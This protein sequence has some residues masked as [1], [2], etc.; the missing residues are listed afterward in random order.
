MGALVNYENERNDPF[1]YIDEPQSQSNVHQQYAQY[2]NYLRTQRPDLY[3]NM[4]IITCGYDEPMIMDTDPSLHNNIFQVLNK[5]REEISNRT[6]EYGQVP[7]IER[8]QLR[9]FYV[10]DEQRFIELYN[11]LSY[12]AFEFKIE[13]V[14]RAAYPNMRMTMRNIFINEYYRQ[15]DPKNNQYMTEQNNPLYDD[16]YRCFDMT[17]DTATNRGK[18][19]RYIASLNYSDDN[20]MVTP[21]FVKSLLRPNISVY[22]WVNSAMEITQFTHPIHKELSSF[23]KNAP[24]SMSVRMRQH[25]NDMGNRLNFLGTR[26]YYDMGDNE[27]VLNRFHAHAKTYNTIGQSSVAQKIAAQNVEFPR[28]AEYDKYILR[29]QTSESKSPSPQQIV[30][31]RSTSASNEL[32]LGN[33]KVIGEELLNKAYNIFSLIDDAKNASQ[34]TAIGQMSPVDR[35]I[36]HKKIDQQLKEDLKPLSKPLKE[37]FNK[38][39]TTYRIMKMTQKTDQELYQLQQELQ[40]LQDQLRQTVIN[41]Y[42]LLHDIRSHGRKPHVPGTK[43]SSRNKHSSSPSV[44]KPSKNIRSARRRRFGQKHK[45]KR[46]SRIFKKKRRSNC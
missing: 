10:P 29:H 12:W 9:Q 19:K 36:I 13:L 33:L 14:E 3:M 43:R 6:L 45:S 16:Y 18:Y 11:T 31:Y 20:I 23:P 4:C 8:R 21:E 37:L 28:T 22:N 30:R 46:K 39:V 40:Q 5:M 35:N 32:P 7:Y 2:A 41:E 25:T 34:L 15:S 1:V 26:H 44:I 24:M 42:H 38:I 27:P 17:A